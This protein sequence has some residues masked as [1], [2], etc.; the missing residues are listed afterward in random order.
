MSD[1][2][3]TD[4]MLSKHLT[5]FTQQVVHSFIPG[6]MQQRVVV[7]RTG[8]TYLSVLLVSS[9]SIS[10]G[11]IQLINTVKLLPPR[12]SCN[13]RVSL[14]SLQGGFTMTTY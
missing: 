2:M 13:R 11:L 8:V 3:S 4:E 14:L 6:N 10:L 12:E 9:K 5:H 7:L 1:T